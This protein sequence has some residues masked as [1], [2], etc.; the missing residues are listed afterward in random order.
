MKCPE[1]F[2]TTQMFITIFETMYSLLSFP[3]NMLCTP[4]ASW[5]GSF[6]L[7]ENMGYVQ[8]FLCCMTTLSIS[9]ASN[10]LLAHFHP[11]IQQVISCFQ[12][13]VFIRCSVQNF[14]GIYKTHFHNKVKEKHPVFFG[15]SADRI[16][17]T[18]LHTSVYSTHVFLVGS[19]WPWWRTH[20]FNKIST[21]SATNNWTI[22]EW[23]N[24]CT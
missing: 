17:S 1:T 12:L 9:V 5:S 14:K 22:S 19:Y 24:I 11:E 7:A 10:Q 13:N 2:F 23:R 3:I 8:S 6:Q 20:D 18:V 15:W 16:L 21:P 4:F